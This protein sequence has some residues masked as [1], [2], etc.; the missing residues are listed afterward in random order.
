MVAMH[1]AR[2]VALVPAR[3]RWLA[4]CRRER[5]SLIIALLL[6]TFFLGAVAG[7]LATHGFILYEEQTL[8]THVGVH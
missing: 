6:G 1:T 5:V 2:P 7:S 8:E 3:L 4:W